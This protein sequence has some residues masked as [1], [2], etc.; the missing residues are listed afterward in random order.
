M[1]SATSG[2]TPEL[3]DALRKLLPLAER[4]NNIGVF[5]GINDGTLTTI[6]HNERQADDCLREMLSVWLRSVSPPPTWSNLAD[7]I[8]PYDP[9]R[10]KEIRGLVSVAI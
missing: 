9:A 10:A 3:R 8:E 2:E 7:A 5:L 1:Q 4:W 6:K